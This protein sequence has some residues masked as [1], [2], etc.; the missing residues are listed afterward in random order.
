MAFSPGFFVAQKT[1][2]PQTAQKGQNF[3]EL[4]GKEGAILTK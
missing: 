4:D 1:C 2:L 3:K